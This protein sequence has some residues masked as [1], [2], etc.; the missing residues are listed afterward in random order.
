MFYEDKDLDLSILAHRFLTKLGFHSEMKVP[1]LMPVYAKAY[2][3]SPAS[4]VDVLGIR[5]DYDFE[6]HLAIVEAKSGEDKALDELLKVRAM[7]DYLKAQKIFLVKSQIHENAREA[8]RH[9]GVVCL[10]EPELIQL[11]KTLSI[12]D[13]PASVEERQTYFLAKTWLSDMRKIRKF[14]S[15]MNYLETDVWA[16]P[17][18]ENL[19]NIIYLLT[20]F[21][22][23]AS[24]TRENL[25]VDF[26]LFKSASMLSISVLHLCRQIITSSLSNIERGTEIYIFGGPAARRQRERLRD[27][28]L[29]IAPSLKGLNMPLEP[30]FLK[31]LK[32]IV[33]YYMLSPAEARLVPPVLNE[34][35][36]N[37]IS[38][39]GKFDPTKWSAN[40]NSIA[41]KLAKDMLQFVASN[42][43]KGNVCQSLPAFL[44][45]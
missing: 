31:G 14:Q 43:G 13:G 9:L 20:N 23:T 12:N 11:L 17:Y 37:I 29:R 39:G 21:L 2:R 38:N 19:N 28:V 40:H 30:P 24:E 18:W 16:R 35:L 5:F 7:G 45:L 32:E 15:L 36:G 27:E 8:G 44:T 34:V 41:V 25:P 10:S 6:P 26:V 3:R 22:K 1:I 4:D 42:C 33:A